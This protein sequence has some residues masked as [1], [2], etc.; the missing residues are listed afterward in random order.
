MSSSSSSNRTLSGNT[1]GGYGNYRRKK[2]WIKVPVGHDPME[3]PAPGG[4]EHWH[5]SVKEPPLCDGKVPP[6]V[7]PIGDPEGDRQCEDCKSRWL[8]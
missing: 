4:V 8:P 2:M 1:G 6:L 7:D 5:V 3:E